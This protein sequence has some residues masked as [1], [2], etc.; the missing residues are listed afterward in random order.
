MK[1]KTL[2]EW[3][4]NLKNYKEEFET[5][6]YEGYHPQFGYPRIDFRTNKDGLDALGRNHGENEDPIMQ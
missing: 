1:K 6:I 3:G 4:V 2:D 5:G